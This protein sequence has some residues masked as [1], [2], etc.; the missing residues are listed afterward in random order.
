MA[1]ANA[2]SEFL[3]QI[4]RE[5]ADSNMS[6][7]GGFALSENGEN[8][9]NGQPGPQAPATAPPPAA[10]PSGDE[11]MVQDVLSSEIGVATMLNRLKQSVASAKEFANFLKKRAAI[12]EDNA[13]GLK[14]L[15][16]TT[17]D[18]MRRSDHLGGSFA[19]AFDGMMGTHSRIAENGIQY[20]MSLLQMAEDLNELAAIAEKQ[21]KGWKQDGLAA[22]H[23][24]ADVEA[25][26]RKSQAKYHSLADEY[27]RVRTGDGQKGGKMFGFKGP[28]SAAQH[29]EELLRKV[30]AADQDYKNKV[31]AY[32]QERGQLLSTT[33]P[34]AIKALQDIVR[35][36]DS[37]LVLQMQKFASFNEKLLLSNGLSVSPLKNGKSSRPDSMSLR[38]IVHNVDTQRDLSEYLCANHSKVPPSKGE[39]MYERHPVLGGPSGGPTMSGAHP[40]AYQAA[41]SQPSSQGAGQPSGHSRQDSFQPTSPVK[42]P[43]PDQH[44]Q[45][46]SQETDWSRGAMP[47]MPAV[48]AQGITSSN[49]QHERSFSSASMLN[50]TGPTASQPPYSN[51]NSFGPGMML[52]GS[53]NSRY[54]EKPGAPSQGPP[55]LGALPFQ[56]PA[57]FSNPP[58]PFSADG[59]PAQQHN[60]GPMGPGQV[61]GSSPP[62]TVGSRPVFGLSLARLYERDGLAVPMVVY[63]CIQAVDLFGLAV[64]GIYRLS[65]S[66]PQVNKMKT[67]FDTD[68]ASPQLDFRNPENFFHDV[69]SV[70]GLLKQFFR[71]LSDPLLTKEHYA[72]FIEAAK[73]ED[74]T[75]RRDS[76]HAI[77]N[78]LPD[79]NYATL[80]AVALHLHRVM[81]NSATNRMTSQNL[82]IVFGPTLMGG[83]VHG[84]I[85]DSGFQCKV[86]DTILQNT[87]QIFD[88]D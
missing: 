71:D 43:T 2:S 67:M 78:S 87:Y 41:R 51:R 36:C 45:P 24:A 86:V 13:N 84:A 20:A 53:T 77:I 52:S 58:P 10:A 76:L 5:R 60:Q 40:P 35:E 62:R 56:E 19:K 11:R 4:S 8:H 23:R 49:Q 16:R 21:R 29:E 47:P 64:E 65:G 70:A 12:E 14:R 80:R 22:E 42:Q 66:L 15:A 17:S 31:Q 50:Q 75:V 33:R 61:R 82:A 57:P 63:Q 32:Q 9:S 54:N 59:G 83:S 3:P 26:M 38:E 73:H 37:G 79:P 55:Q 46:S 30:Q 44:Q 34:E 27:D 81:E 72:G 88:D 6:L 18:N 48:P 7:G 25:Q 39:P 28:K 69:N 68:T 1:D 74:D 85:S